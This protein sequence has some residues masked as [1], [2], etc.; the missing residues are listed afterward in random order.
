M[1]LITIFALAFVAPSAMAGEFGVSL[2]MTK[3]VSAAG[4]LQ[5]MHPGDGEKIE[6]MIKF[7]LAVVFKAASAFV[8][9]YDKDGKVIG[10]PAA[11][12]SPTTGDRDITIMI[13]VQA[14]TV[15][16]SLK[17]A[18]GIASADPI[19][20]DTSAALDVTIHLVK[21]EADVGAPT[22]YSMTRVGNPLLPVTAETV[23]VIVTLSEMPQEFKKGNLSISDNATIT[24][25]PEVLPSL[26]AGATPLQQLEQD[27]A[28]GLV[29]DLTP[30]RSIY[31]GVERDGTAND[32]LTLGIHGYLAASDNEAVTHVAALIAAYT[33]YTAAD[34]AAGDEVE[35][36]SVTL[37]NALGTSQPD[38]GAADPQAVLIP[39]AAPNKMI[40]ISIDDIEIDIDAS[41]APAAA[42]LTANPAL[43]S[44][45]LKAYNLYTAA[46]ALHDAY[47]DAVEME[48]LK[49]E[50][51]QA[52]EIAA[53]DTGV[54]IQSAT[55]RDNMLHRYVVT[56][57]PKYPAGKADIV[58]KVGAFSDTTL[59]RI[60]IHRLELKMGIWKVG[61]KSP[62]RS[63]KRF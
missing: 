23:Q 34:T 46:K 59:F 53:L 28:T 8:I 7:D 32:S 10:F 43:Y 51:I 25:D 44:A 19:N 55:G 22:V 17:I 13:P 42:T 33:A 20:A 5:V 57:K 2:D 60:C 15:K 24:K 6:V 26:E 36:L 61:I 62:S 48:Q 14:A 39:I 40:E 29:D 9:E 58:L 30:L 38:D 11:T 41:A 45:H 18:K 3:D 56:I 27:L 52:D 35:D 31:N 1:S 37:L 49:D 4:D 16:V 47:T 63:A 54:V 12:A 21:A 50:E